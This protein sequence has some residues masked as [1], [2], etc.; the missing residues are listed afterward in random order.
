MCVSPLGVV[1]VSC[2]IAFLS[3]LS[4]LKI[5]LLFFTYKPLACNSLVILSRVKCPSFALRVYGIQHEDNTKK[6]PLR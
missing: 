5:R 6:R 1:V 3:F 2:L 4:S